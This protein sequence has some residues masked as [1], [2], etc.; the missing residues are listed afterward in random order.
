MNST[1]SDNRCYAEAPNKI[2]HT[3]PNKKLL[4]LDHLDANRYVPTTKTLLFT[5]QNF[6]ISKRQSWKHTKVITTH[7]ILKH[8]F[9]KITTKLNPKFRIL[10]Q[11]PH[12]NR[13]E[14]KTSR[15]RGR[16]RREEKKPIC[17]RIFYRKS[18]NTVACVWM[19]MS[20]IND[21]SFYSHKLSFYILIVSKVS[22][23]ALRTQMNGSLD[24]PVSICVCILCKHMNIQQHITSPTPN[25]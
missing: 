8:Y 21:T 23:W 15:R 20:F 10:K 1:H 3:Y 13:K 12:R 4:S 7:R 2:W 14:P 16:G 17:N 9:D 25:K 22:T 19:D 24:Y 5:K 6:Q 18:Q 11:I